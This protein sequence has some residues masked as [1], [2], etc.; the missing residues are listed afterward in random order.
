MPSCR[1]RALNIQRLEM[2]DTALHLSSTTPRNS[3][4]TRR[5]ALKPDAYVPA[6]TVRDLLAHSLDARRERLGAADMI[7]TDAD[8][9]RLVDTTRVT[10]NAWIAK[11]RAIGLTQTKRGFRMPRWQFE[12]AMWAAIPSCWWRSAPPKAGPCCPSSSRLTAPWKGSRRARPSSKAAPNRRS[13]LQSTRGTD[14]PEMKL[15]DLQQPATDHAG[16]LSDLV[17]R[18]APAGAAWQRPGRPVETAAGQH[19]DQPLRRGYCAGRLLRREPRDGRLRVTGPARSGLAVAGHRRVARA[20][21]AVTP[22]GQPAPIFDRT[23]RPGRFCSP[24]GSRPPAPWP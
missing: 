13:R 20:S 24:C 16:H 15:Q 2:K 5:T 9:A 1:L 17:P 3:A 11:G 10:I 23:H 14:S 4:R 22:T 8:A 6:S 18:P 12:P 7:S 19:L 21:F